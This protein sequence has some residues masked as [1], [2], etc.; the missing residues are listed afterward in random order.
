[1]RTTLGKC[2]QYTIGRRRDRYVAVNAA[3]LT[4][5][6]GVKEVDV[7][8]RRNGENQP[9]TH[10]NNKIRDLPVAPALSS[11]DAA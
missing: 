11:I 5:L 4:A 9:N 7:V 10:K 3:T 2:E 6:G 1:M 8:G